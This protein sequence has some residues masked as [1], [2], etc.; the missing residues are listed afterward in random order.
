MYVNR[1]QFF[2]QPCA[3]LISR[4]S[5]SSSCLTL[6]RLPNGLASSVQLSP[7]IRGPGL[8]DE[9][10]HFSGHFPYLLIPVAHWVLTLNFIP[11]PRKYVHNVAPQ[12]P[13]TSMLTFH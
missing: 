12:A 3:A 10:I 4:P 6:H 13:P 8:R 2:P 5:S 1:A 7:W 11:T 9:G